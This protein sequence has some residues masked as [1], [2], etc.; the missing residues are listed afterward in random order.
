MIYVTT[1][2]VIATMNLG[3]NINFNARMWIDDRDYPG[4][5]LGFLTEQQSL[6]GERS[7]RSCPC[8][9]ATLILSLS[10]SGYFWKLSLQY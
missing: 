5:P 10:A 8:P 6:P 7:P 1:L 9:V 4:G 2:F 3:T